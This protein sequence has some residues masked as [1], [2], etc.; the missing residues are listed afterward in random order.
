M[1]CAAKWQRIF[2]SKDSPIKKDTSC[3]LLVS[4]HGGDGGIR[5]EQGDGILARRFAGHSGKRWGGAAVSNRFRL[6]VAAPISRLAYAIVARRR[7]R[8]T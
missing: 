5:K 2:L 1:K 3:A 6:L 7:D 4:F 8:V